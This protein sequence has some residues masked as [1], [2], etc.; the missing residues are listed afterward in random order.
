MCTVQW[1]LPAWGKS[2]CYQAQSSGGRTHKPHSPLA[3]SDRVQAS[4]SP[5]ILASCVFSHCFSPTWAL[6][7]ALLLKMWTP[8]LEKEKRRGRWGGHGRSRRLKTET[9]RKKQ[10]ASI[11]V[12]PSQPQ[13]H[14]E[15]DW[16]I[17][18]GRD[19]EQ[20]GGSKGIY[21]KD[22]GYMQCLIGRELWVFVVAG[23]G[24]SCLGGLNNTVC[25]SGAMRFASLHS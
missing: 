5:Y 14:K 18:R 8:S 4:W 13:T 23:N 16:R 15:W 9:E 22:H 20:V 24:S 12:T 17:P 21:E 1:V 10:W 3:G 6:A 19:G 2:L 25:L 7:T 11:F